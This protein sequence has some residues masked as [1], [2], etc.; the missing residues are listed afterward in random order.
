M[1]SIYESK[2]TRIIAI[3]LV[4]NITLEIFAPT[5]AFALTGG[6]SQP[7]VQSFQPVGTS[8]MVSVASG[9][10]NY[11]IPLMDVGGYPINISYNAGITS[12]QEASWVGLG[13]NINPGVVNRS[14]RGMPD[15][16]KGDQVNKEFH[17]KDN[18]TYGG[19]VGI[20]TKLFGVDF[21]KLNAGLGISYNNYTGMGFDVS[22]NP[23]ISI[24]KTNNDGALTMGLGLSASSN[25]GTEISPSIGFTK[26]TKDRDYVER[27]LSGKV[28]LAFNSRAGLKNLS[29]GFSVQSDYLNKTAITFEGDKIV[30]T[31]TVRN[32]F[33]RN[34]GSAISL[35]PN[36]YVPYTPMN[37]MNL[38]STYSATFGAA[39]YGSHPD[40]HISG[41][42]SGQFLVDKNKTMN[43]Y[44]YLYADQAVIAGNTLMD[45][46]R[47]KD[48][49]FTKQTPNLPLTNFTYD[50]YSVSGQGVGG[51]YR[52][53]RSD[54]GV[55]S[56]PTFSNFGGA[57]T[58]LGLEFGV[59]NAAH[60]G[61]QF[62]ASI[63][64]ISQG[65]WN[66]EFSP[67]TRTLAFRK[68]ENGNPLYEPVYFKQAG[69]KGTDENP[70][71]FNNMGGF[72]PVQLT[73]T[74][75]GLGVTAND[76]FRKG[77]GAGN[78][79]YAI[80][81][82][83][84]SRHKRQN[85][86]QVINPL[87]ADDASNFALVKKIESY[88]SYEMDASGR[89]TS[90]EQATRVGGNYK[91]HHISEITTTRPDG[92]RY[93]YGIPAYNTTQEEYTFSIETSDVNCA[94]GLASYSTTERSQSNKSGIDQYFEKVTTPGYAHS[95]LLTAIVS[96]DYIDITGDGP[97]DDDYGTYTKINYKKAVAKYK[98]R[99]P[100]AENKANYNE[101]LKNNLANNDFTD[102]KAS[103]VYGEKEIWYV[104][105]IE[106]KTHV[107]EFILENREDAN[108]VKGVDGG[109]YTNQ[110]DID[111]N[112]MKK[113]KQINLYAKP[114]KIKNGANALPIK[115]VNFEYD[116]SLC[117]S[118]ENG[119]CKGVENN[120]RYGKTPITNNTG[121]KLTLKRIYFTYGKSYKGT[122]NAYKFSYNV[123]NPSYGMK[124][125]DRWGYYK[126]NRGSTDCSYG[127]T[128]SELSS[129]EFPYVDQNKSNTDRYAASWNLTRIDLPSGGTINVEYESDDYAY[130]QNKGATQMFKVVDA[131]KTL[132]NY[133]PPTGEAVET[134]SL[135]SLMDN[136]A[137]GNNSHPFLIFKLLKPISKTAGTQTISEAEATRI[138]RRDYGRDTMDIYFR[139]L[140]NLKKSGDQA[141]EFVSGYAEKNDMG[142]VPTSG[143]EYTHGYVEVKGSGVRTKGG[144]DPVNPI[145]KA[146]WQ[147]TRLYL[148]RIAYGQADPNSNNFVQIVTSIVGTF[149]SIKQLFDGF[150]RNL[151][152]KDYG[153]EFVRNKSWIRLYNPIGSK[154]GGGHRVKRIVLDDQ[155]KELSAK[156][157]YKSS[158]YGQEYDYTTTI[159]VEDKERIISSGVASYEP[160]LGGDENVFKQPVKFSNDKNRLLV[161]TTESYLEEPFGES[162]FPS[163]GV[164]YSKVTV[165]N[166][167]YANVVKHA[168]GKVVHEFYTA[169][170][171]P[172]I[173]KQTSPLFIQSR[174]IPILKILKVRSKDAMTAT[175]GYVVEQNDMHGQQ[176]AQWVYQE[177]KD[178]PIS[179]VEYFYK[180]KQYDYTFQNRTLKI[181]GLDNELNVIYKD[182]LPNGSRIQK[183]NI[184]VEFDVV[185]DMRES[186]SST[187]SGGTHGNLDAFLAAIFPSAIPVV[188]PALSYEETKFRSS[189]LT[190]VIN[191]SGIID[192][193]V[194]HDLGSSVATKNLLY[195]A[196]TGEVLL[197]QTTNQFDD[198]VYSFTYPAHWGY[199]G[200]GPAYKNIG[201]HFKNVSINN[202]PNA[203][204]YF[205]PGDELM[206]W[207]INARTFVKD[208]NGNIV[209]QIVIAVNN[210]SIAVKGPTDQ[211]LSDTKM[212]N[213]TI[214]RSGRRNMQTVPIGNVTTLKNPLVDANGDG[215]LELSFNQVLSAGA[216]E[217]SENWKTFCECL[218]IDKCLV[219]TYN[220]YRLG[221]AGNWRAIKSHTYLTERTQSVLNNNTNIRKD[222][223]FKSFTPFWLATGST[224]SDWP[225]DRTNWTWVT[226]VTQY[227]PYGMELENQDAL[228]RYS[229]AL[230]GYNNTLPLAVGN[231]AE[232]RELAFDGFEDYDYSNCN[233]GHFDYRNEVL[234]QE[235]QISEQES[236]T[237][238]RS[239]EVNANNSVGVKK[240]L[241]Y[242]K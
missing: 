191:R 240:A 89:Y 232:Y 35:T 118:V 162:F 235:A 98:W 6:P 178:D 132:S 15:D 171:F 141:F 106:S 66:N 145:S 127:N 119:F 32:S 69:E 210:S 104:H 87:N 199:D 114:D 202:L 183:R 161:P 168:T 172:T 61:A 54:V 156:S 26:Q 8:D 211:D 122:L 76:E 198:P 117:T 222:G 188:L 42:F 151:R 180:Q 218:N 176:K 216:V 197:T 130:V 103:F 241:E 44:G 62:S 56:D 22:V 7:E 224:G 146:A 128:L 181:T 101:G 193:V 77:Q 71:F 143:S 125:Y 19:S 189:V 107:A 30:E 212:Y 51:M 86:N 40:V 1:K 213:I 110:N 10:F 219:N 24:G 150:N 123:E 53:Y 64:N 29:L 55:V 28:G 116:Y 14:M 223:I 228:Y 227:S 72:E 83:N 99:V 142:V 165:R 225:I 39:L 91:G 220:K 115:S 68:G 124:D 12:D 97:T 149:E 144:G 134:P 81:K 5:A 11:N 36:T 229:A 242:C 74:R 109:M 129:S 190:K 185:A 170:D 217:F 108:G 34:G 196:E 153:K 16:F 75:N 92:T 148:Q 46:N 147:F 93:I 70:A 226:Q 95:Y 120:T 57:N 173:T 175:Q 231:N 154:L 102:D 111:Q 126:P 169:K 23:S 121:G 177:G 41:Y 20:T 184:G 65:V 221:V 206:V 157:N 9:D 82:T 50:I 88:G 2:W 186:L 78:S 13:W 94:T 208:A 182:K 163:P 160:Q 164:L 234:N 85:R 59:G 237:G 138:I 179:G 58:S 45:F 4:L 166:L 204:K 18:K 239:I 215:R 47:E 131:V 135:G 67:S 200:M 214:I 112:S 25:E 21:F 31:N 201:L 73:L 27:D 80:D 43:A 105:S 238:R 52:P 133:S 60:V 236:H 174:P 209:P 100:F 187:I 3:V 159:K 79:K 84:V 136:N 233:S 48:G 203:S 33:S 207:D 195:D 49:V 230:Y 167:S 113:L 158:Q 194:A 17:M 38:G 137:Q 63:S 140:V 205:V 155:W 90:V 152:N 37:M 192:S 96:A 139:F